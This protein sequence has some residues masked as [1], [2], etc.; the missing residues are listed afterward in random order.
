MKL[1]PLEYAGN[2]RIGFT[3]VEVIVVL[4]LLALASAIVA[5]SLFTS[6]PEESSEMRAIV[7]RVRTAAI[8][9]GETVRLRIGQTG[10]WQAVAGT[11]S[12][13]ELL[14]S[15]Q[16]SG[17]PADLTDLILSPVGTCAPAVGS[18]WPDAL[19]A[20]DPLTCEPPPR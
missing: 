4:V 15:G 16:L 20:F 6:H 2:V 19:A 7:G 14:M 5:P 1:L 12:G 18:V 17:L 3:M 13:G 11:S 10:A 9:R 8:R